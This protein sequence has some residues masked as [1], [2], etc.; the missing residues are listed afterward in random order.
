MN[1]TWHLIRKDL[2]HSRWALLFWAIGIAIPI[3]YS[4]GPRPNDS[5]KD[6]LQVVSM[7][8]VVVLGVGL[9]TDIV[10]SDHPT[11]EG[12][13]WRSM[14]ISAWRMAGAKVL[15]IAGLF[16]ALPVLAAF[17]RSCAGDGRMLRYP[18]EFGVIALVLAAVSFSLAAVAACTSKTSHALVFW[19]A[20]IFGT[21]TL[22]DLLSR[23]APVLDRGT[24]SRVGTDKAL[25]VLALSVIVAITVILNQYLRRRLVASAVLLAGGSVGAAVIGAFWGYF[26]FYQ[27]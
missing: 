16:V 21:A 9:I 15:L 6:Y 7:L 14:P 8:V 1:L 22:T 17:V 18:S 27:G 3:F 13:Q 4:G 26:Y 19:V 25:A 2:H 5:W 23:F 12:A 11:G 24:L 10:Q 20:L